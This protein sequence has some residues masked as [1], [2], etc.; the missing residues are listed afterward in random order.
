[1]GEYGHEQ[2][3]TPGRRLAH[4]ARLRRE[5]ERYIDEFGQTAYEIMLHDC[6]WHVY[7]MLG[8]LHAATFTLAK[9]PT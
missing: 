3:G 5:P 8:R 6:L 2:S 9:P 4:V 1:M 7:R